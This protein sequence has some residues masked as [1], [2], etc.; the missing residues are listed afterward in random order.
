MQS[1]ASKLTAATPIDLTSAASAG[2]VATLTSNVTSSTVTAAATNPVVLADATTANMAKVSPASVASVASSAVATL[3]STVA[4]APAADLSNTA[5][6]VAQLA[7]NP[8]TQAQ[9]NVAIAQNVGAI[10]TSLTTANATSAATLITNMAT[11]NNANATL[12][13]ATTQVA[14]QAAATAVATAAATVQT[15]ALNAGV[16]AVVISSPTVP[17]IATALTNVLLINSYKVNGVAVANGAVTVT[18]PVAS[19]TLNLSDVA[20]ALPATVS[21]GFDLTEAATGRKLTVIV[22]KIAL[23]A[24][25]AAG[26]I[27]ATVGVGSMT[28]GYY[29]TQ[30][31]LTAT[32]SLPTVANGLVITQVAGSTD[33]TLDIP[34]ALA[35][36]PTILAATNLKGT[37]TAT[38]AVSVA[39]L[40]KTANSLANTTAVTIPGAGGMT[41]SG[42]GTTAALTV[43]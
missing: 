18:G 14:Q 32:S 42:Y 31:G 30:A 3:V 40:A 25:P 34:L 39:V 5:P 33:V 22:D 16:P 35:G 24:G 6:T 41:V 43:Q 11:L 20:S 27:T 1:I 17:P 21:L 12:S 26:Q 7:A 4:Q 15:A 9:N 13:V 29:K 36:H 23:A 2:A 8:A 10:A 28:T 19:A 37:F 38:A